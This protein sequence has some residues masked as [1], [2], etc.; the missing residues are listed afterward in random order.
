MLTMIVYYRCKSGMRDAF[1][2]A[3]RKA[4]IAKTCQQENGNI[5][6]DYFTPAFGDEDTLLLVEKWQTD[7]DQKAHCQ[8]QHFQLLSTL[9]D[10]FVASVDIERYLCD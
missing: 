9:K 6:Y 10:Q 2:N 4:D 8:T 7:A 5:Q 1:A 3:L